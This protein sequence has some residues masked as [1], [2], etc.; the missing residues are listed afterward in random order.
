MWPPGAMAGVEDQNPA[1]RRRVWLGKVGEVAHAYL[2]FCFD[3]WTDRR[4]YWWASAADWP[5]AGRCDLFSRR[6]SGQAGQRVTPWALARPR[7]EAEEDIWQ[8][9]RG[10]R[11]ARCCLRQ[12]RPRHSASAG[13]CAEACEEEQEEASATR[14][15]GKERDAPAPPFA[16]LLPI[17]SRAR[18]EAGGRRAWRVLLA[19]R[20]RVPRRGVRREGGRRHHGVPTVHS[21]RLKES[22]HKSATQAPRRQ[23]NAAGARAEPD[24]D[25]AGARFFIFSPVQLDETQKSWIQVEILQK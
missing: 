24:D 14:R 20:V 11:R 9:K 1:S 3:G 17:G 16:S 13:S 4:R 10:R 2:G 7:E 6:N 19:W 5:P 18:C 15:R 25:D 22:V 8:Q 23:V 21:D 12:W